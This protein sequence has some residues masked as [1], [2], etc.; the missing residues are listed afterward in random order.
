[1]QE[2]QIGK[3]M[4]SGSSLFLLTFADDMLLFLNGKKE[5]LTSCM[6]LIHEYEKASGQQIHLKKSSFLISAKVN[7]P[8]GTLSKLGLLFNCWLCLLNTREFPYSRAEASFLIFMSWNPLLRL[9]W[10][11]GRLDCSPLRSYLVTY[12]IYLQLGGKPPGERIQSIANL[13]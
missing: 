2:G 10:K 1:M 3:F 5:S 12:F 4:V 8:E 6:N 9:E 13:N 7:F 11:V